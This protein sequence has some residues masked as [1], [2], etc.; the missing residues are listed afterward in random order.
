MGHLRI[1]RRQVDNNF[2]FSTLI[3]YS[4]S[5]AQVSSMYFS[6]NNTFVFAA[7]N[8]LKLYDIGKNQLVKDIKNVGKEIVLSAL[9]EDGT[10]FAAVDL[11]NENFV[12]V[13]ALFKND[14]LKDKVCFFFP[15]RAI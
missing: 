14:L 3:N 2:Q 5:Y 15:T 6:A 13:V 1:Y 12:H 11:K 7:K 8:V 9:N 10:N 4:G